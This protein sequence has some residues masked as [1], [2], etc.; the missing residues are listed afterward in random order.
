MAAP[1]S[2]SLTKIKYAADN[3]K[4]GM[5]RPLSGATQVQRSVS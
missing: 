4:V 5:V 1:I 2:V 3:F